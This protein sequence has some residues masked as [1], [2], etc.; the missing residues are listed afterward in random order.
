MSEDYT[1][2]VVDSECMR[3]LLSSLVGQMTRSRDPDVR[4]AAALIRRPVL[5]AEPSVLH[6][7]ITVPLARSRLGDLLEAH[8]DEIFRSDEG[9]GNVGKQLLIELRQSV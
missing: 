6:A 3:R 2:V 7:P 4:D 5:E 1:T 9:A 8:I